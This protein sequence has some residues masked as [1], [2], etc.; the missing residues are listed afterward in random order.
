MR[1]VTSRGAPAALTGPDSEGATETRDAT[2]HFGSP[3]WR[4]LE[5]DKATK[6]KF[7]AYRADGVKTA[8]EAAFGGLCAY[9]EAPY[10]VTNDGHIEHYRP[11]GGVDLDD[12]RRNQ[13]PGYYWLAST[14]ENLLPA[15][16]HC[17]VRKRHTYPD[18]TRRFSGKGTAFPLREGTP[19]ATGPG[20]EE[21]EQP[22]LLHPY[23]DEPDL[24]LQ[25]V[26]ELACP[27]N[28]D[29]R[30]K[31]TIELLGLNRPFLI[32]ARRDRLQPLKVALKN[33]AKA[34]KFQRDYPNDPQF[35]ENLTKARADLKEMLQ[36]GKPFA[37]AL[38]HYMRVERE[39]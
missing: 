27:R 37:S 18:G 22:M 10:G 5:A 16:G 24:H 7:E 11:K 1:R 8:L 15:C 36:P 32:E 35:A 2:A 9:C 29:E 23:D 25:F 13:P 34:K 19:R 3:N 6:F 17:N 14:W 33:L 30:G 20:Q 21:D 26:D 31:E 4:E 12:Q 28:G 39:Q 38:A